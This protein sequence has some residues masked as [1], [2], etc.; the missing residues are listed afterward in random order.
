MS[1]E[2]RIELNRDVNER[3]TKAAKEMDDTEHEHLIVE[4]SEE[5]VGDFRSIQRLHGAEAG[6]NQDDSRLSRFDLRCRPIGV[7]GTREVIDCFNL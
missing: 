2:K 4:D 6:I 5:T 1:R 7:T 3:E